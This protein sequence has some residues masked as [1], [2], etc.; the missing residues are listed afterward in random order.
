MLAF[1]ENYGAVAH[2]LNFFSPFTFPRQ[3]HGMDKPG[4]VIDSQG[5]Y[6]SR[7][8]I[9][10]APA[11]Q[12]PLGFFFF[13]FLVKSLTPEHLALIEKEADLWSR[14]PLKNL[15]FISNIW[16]NV[17][18]IFKPNKARLRTVLMLVSHL[19]YKLSEFERV[20]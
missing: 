15:L 16:S 20:K 2:K 12:Q 14:I 17:L 3:L 7:C 11:G 18:R 8:F 13:V 1:L 10:N 9:G 5:L 19:Y 6:S 4:T